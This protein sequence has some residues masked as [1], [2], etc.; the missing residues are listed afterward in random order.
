MCPKKSVGY[1]IRYG[2]T[3]VH[4][5]RN[6]HSM[7]VIESDKNRFFSFL[8]LYTCNDT[9]KLCIEKSSEFIGILTANCQ[10]AIWRSFQRCFW[11]YCDTAVH[12]VLVKYVFS[13]HLYRK[14]CLTDP[15]QG[16][17]TPKSRLMA[18][19]FKLS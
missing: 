18:A 8:L 6:L 13:T 5:L 1:L 14:Y 7:V 12:T 9:G 19:T 16:C 4:T 11:C 10:T 3:G 2:S 17:H 15:T